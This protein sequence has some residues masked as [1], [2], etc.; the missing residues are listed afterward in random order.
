MEI[1]V[2]ND[3]VPG[4]SALSSSSDGHCQRRHRKRRSERGNDSDEYRS[5]LNRNL[6]L[7]LERTSEEN[8]LMATALLGRISRQ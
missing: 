5:L 6:N 4:E 7:A 2:L 8:R 3:H 1:L